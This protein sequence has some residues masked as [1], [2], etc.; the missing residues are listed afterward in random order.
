MITKAQILKLV[1]EKIEG[2]NFF[3][4]DINVTPGNN[5]LIEIDSLQGLNIKDCV[6]ISRHVEHSIDRETED[7]SLEVSSPGLDQPFRVFEQYQKH[8]GKNIEVVTTES[9]KITGK[10]LEVSQDKITLLSKAKK[11]AEGKKSNQITEEQRIISL[12]DI[13][14]TKTVISFK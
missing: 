4:V 12:T 1:N 11:K 10:L 3:I 13:K 14:E 8:I 6:D 5:I 7:F 9:E 2:T